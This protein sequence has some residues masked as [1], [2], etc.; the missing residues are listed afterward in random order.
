MTTS[1][2]P[3]LCR[4]DTFPRKPEGFS[5]RHPIRLTILLAIALL[6]P[7]LG[8]SCASDGGSYDNGA[9]DGQ[10][11]A[12]TYA[13]PKRLPR[14]AEVT[15][16]GHDKLKWTADLDGTVYVYDADEDFIRYTGPIK[17]GQEVVVA[18]KHDAV[19]VGGVVVS[20]E[21]FHQASFHQVYFAP[22]TRTRD[23][24]ADDDGGLLAVPA[25]AI[26]AVSGKDTVEIPD[27][28]YAGTVYVYDED[29]RTALFSHPLEK[30]DRFRVA[31]DG[32]VYAKDVRVAKVT[33]KKGHT[34][35]LYFVRK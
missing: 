26:K 29:A 24:D 5:M 12:K 27:A 32:I 23:R 11:V 13:K 7:Q 14:S 34:L 8:A 21:N 15:R 33:I 19:S 31:R 6:L 35:S 30:G 3:R 20:Q 18:P 9:Q 25:G 1:R 17:R 16:E 10:T 2:F 28:R 22:A 4:R